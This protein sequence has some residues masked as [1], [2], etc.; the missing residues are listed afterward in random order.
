MC[1]LVLPFIIGVAPVSADDFQVGFASPMHKIM[2][3]GE[4]EGFPFQGWIADHYDLNLAGNEHEGFQVVIMPDQVLNNAAVSVSSLQGQDGQG[5]FN[6]NVEV[7]LVGYVDV[8]DDPVPDLNI[9]YPPYLVDYHGWWPDPLLTF[10]QTC[11]Y[12]SIGDRVP[13]WIDVSTRT[14][15]VPGHYA[16]TI[17][18]TADGCVPVE[19][20]LNIHVWDFELPKYPSLPTAFSCHLWMAKNLYG[21]QWSSEMRHKFWD[22]QLAHRLSVT[23][24]YDTKPEYREYIDYWVAGGANAFNLCKI[25]KNNVY[26]LTDLVA[27]LQTDNLLDFAYVYGFDE[28]HSD[29]FPLMYE[30]FSTVHALY[31]GLRTMTTAYDRSFGKSDETAYLR[32]VVDIWV[33]EVTVYNKQAA[34][35]LRAE[36]K[37]MWWYLAVGPRHPCANFMVEYSGIE[38][39][40]LLGAMSYKSKAGGFLYWSMANWLIELNNTPITVGPYT[41]WDPRT[42]WHQ[43]KQ[44]WVS[45]DGSLFCAG[46]D[47][48]IPTIRLENLRD[49]L[50]DYE[51][52]NLLSQVVSLLK[53][54]H[55]NQQQEQFINEAKALL[56]VP[57][58]VVGSV[59]SY[60]RDHEALYAYRQQVAAKILQGFKLVENGPI[61]DDT[62]GDGIGDTC[63]NCPGEF[64]ADQADLDGDDVGDVCDDDDDGDGNDDVV[65]NC[66]RIR[67]E[68]QADNDHDNV[69]DVCDNCPGESNSDQEDVDFDRI[70][71]A[72]DNCPDRPNPNQADDDGDGI[73]NVCDNTPYSSSWLYEKFDGAMSGSDKVG[74]WDQA[75]MN[76][77]WPLTFGARGGVF[78]PGKGV[79]PAGAAMN[80]KKIS[81]RMTTDLEPDMSAQ[82]GLG[83]MGIGI[84]NVVNGFDE[85]PLILEFVVDFNRDP[86]GRYS[87]FYIELSLDVGLGD[88]QAPRFDMVSEDPDLSNGDQGPWTDEN[89]HHVLAYGSFAAINVPPSNPDSGGTKG[90]PM[91]Y[92]GE[93]WHYVKM[94]TDVNGIP[95][96]LW[97]H[98]QGRISVFRMTIRTDTVVLEVDNAYGPNDPYP[99]NL[100]YEVPR[101]YKG[102]FNRLSMTMGNTVNAGKKY[103]VDN[104]LLAQGQVYPLIAEGGCCITNDVG[105]ST[106]E[107]IGQNECENLHGG[108]YLGDFIYCGSGIDTDGDGTSDVC[109]QCPYNSSKITPG[110]CGC[111]VEDV[112]SDGDKTADCNDGC[113]NDPNKTA[114]GICGCGTPDT[115]SDNDGVAD[116]NDGCPN[117]PNKIEPGICGCGTPDSDSDNDTLADCIDNCPHDPNPGQEDGD[118]DGVG[119]VCDNCPI[120]YNPGQEDSDNN[121]VGDICEPAVFSLDILPSD[122]PNLF[123]PNTRSKGRLPMAILGSADV[124]VNDINLSSLNIAGVE[125]PVKV[126]HVSDE[127]DDQYPD[128]K[129]HFSRRGVI[130]ALGLDKLDCNGTVVPITVNGWL[131]SISTRP[132]IATDNVILECCKD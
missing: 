81:Y 64:N 65:D 129:C 114:P 131:L 36:G 105:I 119:D 45:G 83:N 2:I 24:L 111:E 59:L 89:T 61:P 76:A 124:D 72:C 88:D 92:D 63:D 123:T 47:G 126:P 23:E 102:F 128:L 13:F 11:A 14:D 85:N 48:P 18:V 73:G 40:L 44:G 19:L 49:G 80:T 60:T 79:I 99:N 98:Y 112:D 67:N 66:P 37:D 43:S 74:S 109:D 5:A 87:N 42:N 69:G 117:D 55:A 100:A 53:H 127:N 132:V 91:Y 54:C 121:G 3:Q 93:R 84:D 77:R 27:G 10:Q 51:Y 9:E 125:K 22:M 31:P 71:D 6:G 108:T 35:E 26:S 116:C 12:I 57:D 95:V 120:A 110:Q 70:G 7:W 28:V 56:A 20:P 106:C 115:D 32:D 1:V 86:F 68:D 34:E 107:V 122:D 82:Y 4:H 46:P 62:D 90:A 29:K 25:N 41:N 103:Y 94:M 16:G 33:P 39:R 104:V 21:S 30:V 118:D 96:S 101:S 75:S 113:P 8:A 78:A 130:L 50:E 58:S 17:T 15:T 38:P 97:K 52:L